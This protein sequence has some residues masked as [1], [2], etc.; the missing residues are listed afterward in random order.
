MKMRV[1]ERQVNS[2]EARCCA[3]DVPVDVVTYEDFEGVRVPAAEAFAAPG[4]PREAIL[5]VATTVDTAV[6]SP[7]SPPDAYGIEV[8]V[9]KGAHCLHCRRSL[10]REDALT[11]TMYANA[12]A[13]TMAAASTLE[14]AGVG[15]GRVTFF[16]NAV[17]MVDQALDRSV[18][19]QPE[20][21]C[22]NEHADE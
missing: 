19:C 14:K 5:A 4:C 21:K 15:C 11:G 8:Q 16:F 3:T 2:R 10:L 13:G 18:R 7:G 1:R 6:P 12:E 20:G 22:A 17:L 9:L